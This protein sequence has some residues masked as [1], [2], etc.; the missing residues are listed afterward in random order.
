MGNRFLRKAAFLGAIIFGICWIT[1]S[2]GCKKSGPTGTGITTP[3][4]PDTL[5]TPVTITKVSPDTGAYST[6]VTIT[7]TDFNA[8]ASGDSVYF[9][10][11]SANIQQASA[12]QLVVT[13]PVGAGT[14][15]VKVVVGSKS[16]IG[17]TF[18]YVYTVMVSTLAGIPFQPGYANGNGTTAQFNNPTGVAVDTSGNVYVTDY[19]NSLIRVVTSAGVVS[20]LA[21]IPTKA[22]YVDGGPT[23][24]EF[25][26]PFGPSLDGQGNLYVADV[27]N[28][29][30]REIFPN[31]TV[32]TIAGSSV[33]QAGYAN[34]EFDEPY[35]VAVSAQGFIYVADAGNNVIRSID[36]L[37]GG[38]GTF[39]G[40][41]VTSFGVTQGGYADGAASFARFYA[42]SGVAV[43]AQGNVYVADVANNRVREISTS[44]V[45][46][47]LAG[48]GTAGWEDGSGAHTELN[49]PYAVAVDWQ[50]NV[51]VADRGNA[52]IR[53][54]TPAGVVSTLAGNG[55]SGHVDGAGTTAEF[56]GPTGIAIDAKGNIYVA[57][58]YSSV[59]RK[60]TAQ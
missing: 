49:Y 59:I 44:G 4:T 41:Y 27:G 58:Q 25:S 15:P 28:N 21:G 38:V 10:G 22:G 16:C 48:N 12:T 46:S 1:G 33:G 2:S 20:T 57:D 53:K 37:T 54:I 11:V 60:I 50:G 17:P 30:V 23:K 19:N 18:N 3:V 31:G 45:V 56:A 32:V 26:G 29:A 47:T 14:G 40:E 43:D 52:V 7:G 35:G 39:A 9:N 36:L 51:Y 5:V 24:A 42:P 13:V 8:T 6:S 34:G 55:T